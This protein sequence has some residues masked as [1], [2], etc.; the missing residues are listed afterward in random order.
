M[1]KG[2]PRARAPPPPAGRAKTGTG[3]CR[4]GHGEASRQAAG[5]AWCGC[6]NF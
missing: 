1:N 4:A 5:E 3:S 2:V 6:V